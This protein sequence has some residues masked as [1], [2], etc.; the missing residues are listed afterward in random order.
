MTRF[1][2]RSAGFGGD[3]AAHQQAG[4]EGQHKGKSHL[5]DHQDV[6]QRLPMPAAAR[7]ARAFFEHG[8]QVEFARGD[9]RGQAGNQ[10]RGQG[11]GTGEEQD[12]DIER[13]FGE[14]GNVA[15]RKS[16]QR[17]QGAIRQD[18]SGH[19]AHRG[20]DRAF[21]EQLP[22]QAQT[23]CADGFAEG[24][25]AGAR[26]IAGEQETGNVGAGDQQNQG[27]RCH[28]DD[29]CAA[30]ISGGVLREKAAE[31][32]MLV[33][34]AG[35]DFGQMAHDGV[36]I[37][38]RGGHG[39]SGH[40]SAEHADGAMLAAVHV[41]PGPASERNIVIDAPDFPQGRGHPGHEVGPAAERERLADDV[42]IAAELAR[43]EAVIQH[44]DRLGAG[45]IVRI[46]EKAA[47]QGT[48][49]EKREVGRGHHQAASLQG[50]AAAGERLRG[51]LE[52]G[53][54]F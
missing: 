26:G 9:D 17:A 35:I 5:G 2:A 15:G 54:R 30:N 13:G 53:H 14:A 21:G 31:A 24:Q 45:T 4:A 40:Q 12:R 18:D 8:H 37:G 3:Q 49:S 22:R 42:R 38:A 47:E 43:P 20:N 51:E 46:V 29:Q 48:H 41:V 10:A 39:D 32:A 34:G 33:L 52:S 50:L 28:E 16:D 27:G 7:Q 6:A 25:F 36:E 1:E 19:S 44:E 23:A 11:N